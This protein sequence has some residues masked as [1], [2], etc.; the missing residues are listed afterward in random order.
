MTEK[1]DELK[2]LRRTLLAAD[3]VALFCALVDTII[4]LVGGVVCA[5]I[6]RFSFATIRL[7]L[8]AYLAVGLPVV[9]WKSRKNLKLNA[10]M[11]KMW[12]EAKNG[13]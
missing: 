12:R 13:N 6:L 4:L 3:A 5:A 10:A 7:P 8:W 2:A 11:R 9:W 1:K